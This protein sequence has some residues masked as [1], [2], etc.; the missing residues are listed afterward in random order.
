[1]G[2]GPPSL[3]TAPV[4][5]GVSCR[6]KTPSPPGP[7]CQATLA[8]LALPCI[9]CGACSARCHGG[10]DRRAANSGRVGLQAL[11]GSSAAPY[12]AGRRCYRRTPVLSTQNLQSAQF[13]TSAGSTWTRNSRAWL[14]ALAVRGY[15]VHL[16]GCKGRPYLACKHGR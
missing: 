5:P 1:M 16:L 14:A 3:Q 10:Q 11:P 4:P 12:R 2:H 9:C 15:G 6:I 8:P 7:P 13:T